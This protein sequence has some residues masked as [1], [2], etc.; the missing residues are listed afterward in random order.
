MSLFWG[1]IPVTKKKEIV[2]KT[3]CESNTGLEKS[4]TAYISLNK[5]KQTILKVWNKLHGVSSHY[6]I[7]NIYTYLAY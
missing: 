7:M 2:I 3:L 5:R 4:Y 6:M 1:S